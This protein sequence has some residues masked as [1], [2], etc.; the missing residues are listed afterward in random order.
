MLHQTMFRHGTVLGE[1]PI[2]AWDPC[3]WQSATVTPWYLPLQ[4]Y[5]DIW[6]S[7]LGLRGSAFVRT[8]SSQ[9]ILLETKGI[10]TPKEKTK[11]WTTDLWVWNIDI[12]E[13]QRLS[14]LK[15]AWFAWHFTMEHSPGMLHV[16]DQLPKV[17]HEIMSTSST[18]KKPWGIDLNF[19]CGVFRTLG[20]TQD[21]KKKKHKG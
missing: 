18:G 16:K 14:T 17:S 8:S 15:N 1:M 3:T 4:I 13:N 20:K 12:I 6:V 10:N 7:M 11:N 9:H 5:G 21:L 2:L 19:L